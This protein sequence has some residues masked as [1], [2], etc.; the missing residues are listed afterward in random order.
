MTQQHT[1]LNAH[2]SN[3]TNLVLAVTDELLGVGRPTYIGLPFVGLYG[4]SFLTC[5]TTGTSISTQKLR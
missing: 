3:L 5:V 1:Q 2:T 4:K